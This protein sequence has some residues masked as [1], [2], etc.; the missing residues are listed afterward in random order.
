MDVDPASIS[1]TVAADIPIVGPVQ[2]VLEE[3]LTQIASVGESARATCRT[4][5]R[6]NA[7]GSRSMNGG[8]HGLWTGR[9]YGQSKKIMPQ[10]VIESLYRVTDGNAY[11]TADVGQHQMFAAQYRFDQPRRWINSGAGHHGF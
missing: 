4:R 8:K 1:K 10:Q 2:T 5:R 3:L 7:G 11:I 6:W 9:R